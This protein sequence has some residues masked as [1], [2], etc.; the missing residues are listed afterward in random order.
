MW[1]L[2]DGALVNLNYVVHLSILPTGK[3]QMIV[4]IPVFEA[5]NRY[6][7]E[8]EWD[9]TIHAFWD[10]LKDLAHKPRQHPWIRSDMPPEEEG[11]P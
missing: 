5:P 10:W 8:F 11:M 9:D 4:A 7:I 1:I 6:C 2:I 3:L